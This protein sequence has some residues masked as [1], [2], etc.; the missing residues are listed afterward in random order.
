MANQFTFIGKLRKL[1][2]NGYTEQEF[3]GGLLKKRA[4]C[5]IVCGDNVQWLDVS[6]LV[7]K[8]EKK[9]KIY[10]IKHVENGQDEKMEVKWQDRFNEDVVNSVASYKKFIVDTDT[11]AHRQELEKDGQDEELEKSKKKRKTFIHAADFVDYL[12]K[13]LDSEKAKEMVFKVTG[14]IEFSY[15][16]KNGTY[17]RTFVPQK[18]TRVP[19]TTTQICE[20]T[21]KVYFSENAVDDTMADETGDIVFNGYV[22]NYFSTIKGNAFVP[23]SFTVN[24]DSEMAEGFKFVFGDVEDEKVMEYGVV[25]NFINGAQQISITEDMLSD[26]QK[27]MI[28]LK[29]TTLEKIAEELGGTVR[30]NRVTKT[31]LKDTMRGYSGGA[32]E[33]AFEPMDLLKKPV[34][35]EEPKEE[36]VADI[37]S[38]DDEI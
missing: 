19:D 22:Q 11:Y 2:E 26:K 31:E 24:K 10:T 33:A 14:N 15:S 27:K 21:M 32:V 5:Q 37:F 8:D 4:Q 35:V 7:W 9:N 6:A 20:G 1:K 17:Y 13:V 34:K 36:E 12:V 3:A 16:E 29:M 30:G 23:M 18:V 28:A 38:D 25:A